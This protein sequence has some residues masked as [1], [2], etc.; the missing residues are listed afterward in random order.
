METQLELPYPPSVNNYWRRVGQRTI[1]SKFGRQYKK[2]VAK[3][4]RG[5]TPF[6]SSCRLKITILCCP[7]DRRKRDLDNVLK[8]LLDSLSGYVYNDD[9]QIDSIL[10]I[11]SEVRKKGLIFL[12]VIEMGSNEQNKSK[13]R[14]NQSIK[15]RVHSDALS[16][17][18]NSLS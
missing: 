9:S 8:A 1:I 5:L 4:C 16:E 10:I 6:D 11:R 14:S 13:K 2:E 15:S 17:R 3:L 12:K 7:P 18:Q